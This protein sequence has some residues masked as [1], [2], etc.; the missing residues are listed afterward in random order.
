M[1]EVKSVT[2]SQTV[3]KTSGLAIASLILGICGFCTCGLTG[4]V[5]L[6]LGIIGLSAIKKSAGQLKGQGLAIA[7]IVV[8]AVSL[9]TLFIA[10]LMALLMP[11]LAHTKHQARAV[12][13]MSNARQLS[14][15]FNIYCDENNGHF[16]PPDNWPEALAPYL[17][18]SET[19]LRLP[20]NTEAGRAYAMNTQLNNRKRQE[21]K[22][23]HRTVLVF[24]A[25]FGSPPAGGPELLPEEPRGLGGRHVIGFV[26]GHVESVP[27]E[28]VDELIWQPQ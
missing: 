1:N 8:S 6:V 4:V 11:A 14:L 12:I 20:F 25:R 10:L 21:I 7:G 17:G 28:R 3:V 16:P 2:E 22:E 26:D 9:V 15:A 19:I 5:G 27:P 24:E 13:Q 23:P 18:D